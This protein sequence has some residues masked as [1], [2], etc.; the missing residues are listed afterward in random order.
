M[1]PDEVAELDGQPL[2]Q[3]GVVRWD[4]PGE[5]GNADGDCQVDQREQEIVIH[6]DE[7]HAR[8]PDPDGYDHLEVR[9]AASESRKDFPGKA[10][11]LGEH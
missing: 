7:T 4:E 9:V 2:A 3:T 1:R 6:A 8:D 10:E 5:L 11:S